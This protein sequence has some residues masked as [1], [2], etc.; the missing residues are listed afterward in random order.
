MLLAENLLTINGH[1]RPFRLLSVY[2]QQ[3]GALFK[4]KYP[5]RPLRT[6]LVSSDFKFLHHFTHNC[7]VCVDC[8][9]PSGGDRDTQSC[10]A[11]SRFS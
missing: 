8:I 3:P 2:S 1:F 5:V 6:S 9:G 4:L 10:P 7:Q 11:P